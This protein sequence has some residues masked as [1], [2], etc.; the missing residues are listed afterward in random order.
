MLRAYQVDQLRNFGPL[1]FVRSRALPP[2]SGGKWSR[3]VR[4]RLMKRR[5]TPETRR[6]GGIRVD[7]AQQYGL[8]ATVWFNGVV[9]WARLLFDC[10]ADGNP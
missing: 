4:S 2:E 9:R 5:S 10:V 8:S 1:P 6:P 7:L 3:L